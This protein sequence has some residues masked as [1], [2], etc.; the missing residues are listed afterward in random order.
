MEDTVSIWHQALQWALLVGGAIVLAW[1]V[2]HERRNPPDREQLTDVLT[3]RAWKLVEVFLLLGTLFLLYIGAGFIGQFFQG[4]KR[5]WLPYVQLGVTII[6][7]GIL[8]IE[9]GIISRRRGGNGAGKL[10]YG[11]FPAFGKSDWP[12]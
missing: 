2:R 10:G 8:M 12:H 11:M 6:I 5:D 3:Q 9:M 1:I 7:Y 4:E